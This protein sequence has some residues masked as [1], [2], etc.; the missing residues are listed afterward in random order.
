MFFDEGYSIVMLGSHFH[1]EFV[2][3]MPE[4]YCPGIPSQDADNIKLVTHKIL[5]K[6]E[7]K[8]EC[9]FDEKIIIGTS[10]GAL[11]SLFVAEKESKNNTL[12]ITKYIAISPPVELVYAVEQL[13]KNS[14]ELD[15]NSPEVKHKTAVTAAK[16]LQITKMKENNP[17]MN[18]SS[19]PL[20]NRKES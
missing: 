4:G 20:Q 17:D 3:S 7:N 13:D 2:R 15:N 19:L 9:K 14:D 12:G 5:D 1:W 18:I 11:S 8:Y 6:L 10:F 16:I